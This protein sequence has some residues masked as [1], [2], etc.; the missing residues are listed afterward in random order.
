MPP[1]FAL[2]DEF[3]PG[4]VTRIGFGAAFRRGGFY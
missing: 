3:E 1:K 4:P 2:G